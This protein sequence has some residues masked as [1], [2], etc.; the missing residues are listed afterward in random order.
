MSLPGTEARVRLVQS[1]RRQ[2][3][4]YVAQN[5]IVNQTG[6]EAV[7]FIYSTGAIVGNGLVPVVLDSPDPRSVFEYR[8]LAQFVQ[9]QFVEYPVDIDVD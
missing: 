2:S 3:H 7:H 1:V 8:V 5:A 4:A 9:P 6:L